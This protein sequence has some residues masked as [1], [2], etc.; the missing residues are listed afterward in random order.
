MPIR[1]NVTE[2]QAEKSRER[3]FWVRR[4]CLTTVTSI[5]SNA[6]LRLRGNIIS[7]SSTSSAQSNE[8]NMHSWEDYRRQTELQGTFLFERRLLLERQAVSDNNKPP[9][10][11]SLSWICNWGCSCNEGLAVTLKRMEIR[12]RK[13]RSKLRQVNDE[14]IT[15][16]YDQGFISVSLSLEEKTKCFL[17]SQVDRL[18][19]HVV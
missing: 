1:V 19:H 9:V 12:L 11:Q 8:I 15:W 4:R 6:I 16:K 7:C 17:S 3:M 14:Q 13:K 10:I 2:F 5:N 18:P